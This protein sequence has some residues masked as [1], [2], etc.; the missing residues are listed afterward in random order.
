MLQA[1]DIG[2]TWVPTQRREMPSNC[3]SE[4]QDFVFPHKDK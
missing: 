1:M 4:A 2:N 3:P